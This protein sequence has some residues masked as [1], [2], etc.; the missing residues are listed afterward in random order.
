MSLF[1]ADAVLNYELLPLSPFLI[2]FTS[3]VPILFQS[4]TNR[5]LMS[6]LYLFLPILIS[7]NF[8]SGGGSGEL[9]RRTHCWKPS[10]HC[11]LI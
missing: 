11:E 7:D 5:I 4:L 8:F 9:L 3:K 6:T 10:L 2:S 1:D